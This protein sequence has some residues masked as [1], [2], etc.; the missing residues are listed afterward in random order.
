MGFIQLKYWDLKCWTEF[1]FWI[2]EEREF[3]MDE[4]E[5]TNVFRLRTID[6]HDRTISADFKQSGHVLA[7]FVNYIMHGSVGVHRKK[8]CT[9]L[10]QVFWQP[11]TDFLLK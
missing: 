10:I 5:N 11:E 2:Y 1:E 3:Q 9:S 6:F 7:M 4:P 8:T